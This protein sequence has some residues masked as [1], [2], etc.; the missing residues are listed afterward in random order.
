VGASYL[1][2]KAAVRADADGWGTYAL[3]P[4]RAGETV[5]AFG[6][7]CVSRAE[8]DGD[9]VGAAHA[10]QIDDEL[11]LVTDLT[12]PPGD[13]ISHSCA[14]NCGISAGVLVVAMRDIA[15][16]EVLAYDRAMTTGCDVNEFECAC[17]APTCRHKVTGQDWMLPE[18]QVAYRGFFSPYLAKRISA[19]V[20]TGAARRA[21]AL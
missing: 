9:G 18:L 15:T 20:R 6:G 12:A 2:P 11:F 1:S 21:F 17:G 8:L 16:G 4:I 7:R 13:T 10:V 19:L 3:E 14:P 5:A